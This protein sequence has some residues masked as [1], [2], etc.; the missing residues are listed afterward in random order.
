MRTYG[1]E[2]ADSSLSRLGY[3]YLV[4][5]KNFATTHGDLRD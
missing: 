2:T 5:I 3:H 1:G 4:G